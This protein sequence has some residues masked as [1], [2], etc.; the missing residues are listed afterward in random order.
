MIGVPGCCGIGVSWIVLV[1][2]GVVS[3]FGVFSFG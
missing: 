3:G 2:V 1:G